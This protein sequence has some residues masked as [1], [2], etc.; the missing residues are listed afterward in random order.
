M[1]LVHKYKVTIIRLEAFFLF[2]II[3][4]DLVQLNLFLPFARLMRTIIVLNQQFVQI[5][6]TYHIKYNL[7][8]FNL[9]RK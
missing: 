5:T 2:V 3:V 9:S 1:K 7:K 6:F 4:V 8:H